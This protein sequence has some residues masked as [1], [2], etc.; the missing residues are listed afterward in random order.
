VA[1][2]LHIGIVG[3]SAESA[4]Q[5]YCTISEEGAQLL[6]PRVHLEVS[7]HTQP[8]ADYM[9][10]LAADDM[11]GLGQLMLSSA[12]KLAKAGA[13]FLICPDNTVHQAFGH[14]PPR[15]P[16]P[17]LHV[18]DVVAQEAR[19]RGYRKLG[20]TGMRW[21]VDSDVYPAKL[22][23]AGLECVKPPPH[24]R[25]QMN[26]AIMKELVHGKRTP[27]GVRFFQWVIDGLK[28]D[29]CD[30]VVLGCSE[31]PL[32]IHEGNSPLPTLDA[33]RLLARAALRKA[34]G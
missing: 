27:H 15:W 9:K 16:L 21:L 23:A 29:G 14:A 19:A 32:I 20:L 1:S 12:H 28:A 25:E 3:C 24:E 13:Q 34:I 6:G 5:C 7:V 8:Q 31:I 17:W 4:S 26:R 11:P 2:P 10:C 30:A 22:S 33:T 18:A